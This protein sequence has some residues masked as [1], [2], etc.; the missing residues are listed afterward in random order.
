MPFCYPLPPSP[1]DLI[2]SK[3][4][5]SPNGPTER[6]P[7]CC[8]FEPKGRF[9]FCGLESSTVERFDLTDGKRVAFPGGHE[10]WVFS[11]AFS[12][13]GTKTFSGG[14]DGRI[15]EWETSSAARLN[16][17]AGPRLIKGGFDP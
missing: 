12:L 1:P 16:R 5:W 6:P 15:T 8:R 3:R 2:P 17:S 10:S 11:L 4:T 9:L 7:V 13:D 14:G